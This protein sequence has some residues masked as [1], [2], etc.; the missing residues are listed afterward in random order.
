MDTEQDEVLQPKPSLLALAWA[1]GNLA[2]ACRLKCCGGEAS[3]SYR[4]R[5]EQGD[6]PALC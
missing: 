3:Y 5:W 1:S 4:E 2:L 6:E